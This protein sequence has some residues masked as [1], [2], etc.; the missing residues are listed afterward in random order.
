MGLWIVRGL[1]AAE[2][3]QVWAENCTQ[4]GAQFTISVPAETQNAI[5]ATSTT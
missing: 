3:G 1:L 5:A 2:N 4:G